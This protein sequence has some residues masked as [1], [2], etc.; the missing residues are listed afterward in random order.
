MINI[1]CICFRCPSFG[2]RLL[3][4]RIFSAFELRMIE[5]SKLNLGRPGTRRGHFLSLDVLRK[6]CSLPQTLKIKISSRENHGDQISTG[7][8]F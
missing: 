2:Y 8:A 6:C 5:L 4:G 7:N 3:G 1:L